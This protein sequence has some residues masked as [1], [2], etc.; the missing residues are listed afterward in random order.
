ML[1]SKD[2]NTSMSFLSGQLR[3]FKLRLTRRGLVAYEPKTATAIRL[4]P[5]ETQQFL[6]SSI[7]FE[8]LDDFCEVVHLEI[9]ARCQLGCPYCYNRSGHTDE[10][11]TEQWKSIIS[12]LARYG[13]FQVTFGGGEPTLRSDLKELALYTRRL[14]LNLCMTTNGVELHAL[15]PEALCLFNQ[16]NVSYHHA[17]PGGTFL[18]ALEHLKNSNTPAGINFLLTREY[19]GNIEEVS[20]IAKQFDAEL[21][22]LSAKGVSDAIPPS[23]VLARARAPHQ[24]GVKVAVDALSCRNAVADFCLQKIRFCTVDSV[25][26]VLPCSF[27][28]EPIGNL[29]QQHFTEIWRS[30]GE[31]VPCPFGGG[32]N[33]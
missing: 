15:G 5:Q 29:L 25:G 27:V 20:A 19:E 16:I 17:A 26:N 14:G 8:D 7:C 12:D 30:R 13:V 32:K 3:H 11:P 18:T 21:L 4:D 28:R 6:Q 24:R 10:L 1:R 9:S 23:E 22:V 33:H 31:Q 2:A